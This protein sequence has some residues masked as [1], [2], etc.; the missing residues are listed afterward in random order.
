VQAM[1]PEQGDKTEADAP[2]VI[3]NRRGQF[4]SQSLLQGCCW[5]ADLRVTEP[6]QKSGKYEA[7]TGLCPCKAVLRFLGSGGST[8][9]RVGG[10]VLLDCVSMS[11]TQEAYE[12]AR[13]VNH[14]GK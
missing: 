9:A 1:L 8:R 10:L 11:L 12:I 7:A 13:L 6:L 3:L 4:L 14:N 2:P 5:L